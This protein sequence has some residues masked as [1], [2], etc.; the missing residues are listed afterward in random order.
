MNLM[1]S[2]APPN[3]YNDSLKAFSNPNDKTITRD[4]DILMSLRFY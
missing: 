3:L 4:A 2:H 1:Y